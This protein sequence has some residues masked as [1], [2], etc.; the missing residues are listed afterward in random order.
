M[1]PCAAFHLVELQCPVDALPQVVVANWH[2]FAEPFPAPTAI[3]PMIQF[4]SNAT[5]HVAAAR[6]KRHAGGLAER[7]EAADHGEQFETACPGFRLRVGRRET[8][9][10]ADRLQ[11][12]LPLRRTA[13]VDGCF[14]IEQKVRTLRLH[15]RSSATVGPWIRAPQ[16][17]HVTT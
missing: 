17:A 6:Q 2:E 13:A 10:L 14:R 7:F 16:C 1:L 15:G 9:L 5:S 12:E 4:A 3:A 8:D 11:H